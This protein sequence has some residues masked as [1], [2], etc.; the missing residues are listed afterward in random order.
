MTRRRLPLKR[1]RLGTRKLRKSS[2]S[3]RRVLR[4]ESQRVTSPSKKRWARRSHHR[5]D[6]RLRRAQLRARQ[7]RPR[8]QRLTAPRRRRPPSNS[9]LS[10]ESTKRGSRPPFSSVKQASSPSEQ[11]VDRQKRQDVQIQPTQEI[12]LGFV[13]QHD[14]LAVLFRAPLQRRVAEE[15][16]RTQ[17]RNIAVGRTR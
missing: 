6:R 17:E 10:S 14:H 13:G 3:S 7:N 5:W 9:R 4:I 16:G 12:V 8:S 2:S 11:I 15:V 1:K